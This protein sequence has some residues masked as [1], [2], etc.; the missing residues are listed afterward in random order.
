MELLVLEQLQ[1]GAVALGVSVSFCGYEKVSHVD[2]H[3]A[4]VSLGS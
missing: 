3:N 1:E 4:V 2:I